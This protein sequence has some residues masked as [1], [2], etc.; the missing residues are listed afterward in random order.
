MVPAP[1]SFERFLLK[2]CDIEKIL[3]LNCIAFHVRNAVKL[4]V[5]IEKKNI[6]PNIY[7]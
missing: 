2:I 4:N 7:C 6:T 1:K 5:N 3:L